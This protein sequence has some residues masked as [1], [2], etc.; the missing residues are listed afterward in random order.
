MCVTHEAKQAPVDIV[1]KPAVR[2]EEFVTTDPASLS[3]HRL[4][5]C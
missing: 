5:G 3:L 1:C 4:Q 2:E